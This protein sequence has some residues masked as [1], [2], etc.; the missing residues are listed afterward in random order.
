M[1]SNN[2]RGINELVGLFEQT[3]VAMQNH[4]TKAIDMTLVIRNWLFGWYIVEFEGGGVDRSEL[5]GKELIKELSNQLS[6]KL[7]KGFSQRSLELHRKFYLSYKKIAQTQSAQS[8][9][10]AKLCIQSSLQA[11]G[12]GIDDFFNVKDHIV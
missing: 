9:E 7:G 8:L 2:E 4:A 3:Q 10:I 6:G 5:Y 11:S 12:D 1:G